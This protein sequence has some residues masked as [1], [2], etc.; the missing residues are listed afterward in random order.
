MII[1]KFRNFHQPTTIRFDTTNQKPVRGRARCAPQPK[2]AVA[3]LHKIEEVRETLVKM[4]SPALLVLLQHSSSRN[5]N[6]CT[7]SCKAL[8][9]HG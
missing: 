6:I 3:I 9:Q 2:T 8:E 5:G 1:L 4:L 7:L